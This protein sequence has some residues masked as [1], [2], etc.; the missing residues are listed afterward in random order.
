MKKVI[1][2]GID[3]A[4]WT[5]ID[6]YL[7]E[8]YLPNF[9]YIINNGSKG[10]LMSTF[11][12]VTLPA[13][14]SI[15]TGVNPGKHGITDFIIS[16]RDQFRLAMSKDRKVDSLWKILSRRN[17]RCIVLNDPTIFPPEKINGIM[18]TGMT[19]P[20]NSTYVHPPEMVHEIEKIANG[21]IYEM[22]I[23]YYQI[24]STDKEKAYNM[25]EEFSRKLAKVALHLAKN[26]EWNILA[27]IF[28][29]TDRLQHF[30][31]SEPKYIRRHY[32]LID[33]I[34]KDFV[35]LADNENASLVVLSDHGFGPVNRAFYANPWL[36]KLGLQSYRRHEVLS[37]LSKMGLT[38]RRL[39]KL[40]RKM[41][42]Y[43]LAYTFARKN[44]KNF[45]ELML[46]YDKPI[47]MKKSLAF[48]EG[49]GIYL[50]RKL[51]REDY[52]RI[53]NEIMESLLSIQDNGVSIV[54][55]VFKREEVIWGSWSYRA[56]DIF[57]ILNEGYLFRAWFDGSGDAE[58]QR[59]I[60]S[61]TAMKG[62]SK[63]T[64][65]HRPEGIFLAYGSNIKKGLLMSEHVNTW[66]VAPT[67][68]HILGLPALSYMDGHVCSSIF[69]HM[70]HKALSIEAENITE[71]ERLKSKI[72]DINYV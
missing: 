52:E 40:L 49:H 14:T 34:L 54:K 46:F 63:E 10:T 71:K 65:G 44:F 24:M 8:G 57:T 35:N 31:W 69:N 42:M 50:N 16:E 38:R 39:I 27:P 66:D 26:Y 19:T 36:R 15:F 20:P 17:M 5:I 55:R 41:H 18:T 21:Y 61:P 13:W 22:P 32:V 53:R 2:L 29:S 9:S 30:Y 60:A 23:D 62:N 48:A 11:P 33:K 28:T 43:E 7:N 3:G 6:K 4:T 72:K 47:D 70:E 12:M 59:V 67:I 45:T 37:V 1:L 25:L 68:L 51:S 58:K 64:G 56:P